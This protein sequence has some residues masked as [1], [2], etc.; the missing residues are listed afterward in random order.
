MIL[1][2]RWVTI[3]FTVLLIVLSI[4][5][6][7]MFAPVKLG[8]QATYVI[9]DGTSMEPNFHLGDLAIVREASSYQVGDIVTYH[10]AQLN[11][12]VIHRII[13]VN[14]NHFIVKGDNNSWIDAY[15]PTLNE[16]IGKLWIHIPNLGKAFMWL[17]VPLNMALTI[18]LLGGILMTSMMIKPSQKGKRKNGPSGN[19]GGALEG[20]LYVIG[21]LCLGFLGLTIFTFTRPLTIANNI[22]YQQEGLFFYSA[23]GTPGVYDTDTVHSGEPVFPKLT[24]FLNVGFAYNL[25]SPELQG[26]SGSYQMN[27]RVMDDQSG[28]QRTIPLIQ[29]TAF[30]S[31]SY[32]TMTTL[33]LCQIETMVNL[34]EQETGL[35]AGT[36]DLDIVMRVVTETM[37][38]GNT[39]NDTFQPTLVFK[40]DKTH[41]FLASDPTQPDPLRFSKQGLANGPN[42]QANTLPLL[43]WQPTV[44]TLRVIS[45]FGLGLSLTALAIFGWYLVNKARQSQEA[46]I[47]LK[48]GGLLM[49]VYEGSLDPASQ[50]IDVTSMD[51]LA[52]LAERQN[53]MILHM[54]LNFL[55]Y[56]LVQSNGTTYRYVISSGRQGTIATE[57]AQDEIENFMPDPEEKSFTQAEPDWAEMPL[58]KTETKENKADDAYSANDKVV[59]HKTAT[60]KKITDKAEPAQEEITGYMVDAENNEPGLDEQ[61][62][63]HK[64][65]NLFVNEQDNDFEEDIPVQKEML[66]YV[67]GPYR[68][69]NKD[70]ETGNEK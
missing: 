23:T 62:P 30:K 46:L 39:T 7:L 63:S 70:K 60:T 47:R 26:I 69:N 53:T 11:A 40:F 42:L 67:F 29:E 3:F 35:H 13:G 36:Y 15:Q 58:Y 5:I 22:Q 31:N 25:L 55:H 68:N 34:V 50:V 48:Y 1:N 59:E 52:K 54:T 27:A 56:Y 44:L 57:P 18:G 12:N 45:L 20:I 51:D 24:C 17:R 37:I 21:F 19:F 61:I 65:S 16:I 64:D 14:Q 41:F 9:V 38:A 4:V 28:W 10:D 66:R 8:G 6:W 32:F 49:D 43:G 33:D 2:R